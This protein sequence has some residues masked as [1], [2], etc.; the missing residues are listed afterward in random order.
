[1]KRKA[2]GGK[3]NI[4]HENIEVMANGAI[5]DN[6]LLLN[7]IRVPAKIKRQFTIARDYHEQARSVDRLS[8]K[9]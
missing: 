4:L 5:L 9:K 3:L 7:Q 6:S 8:S 1:M 2:A